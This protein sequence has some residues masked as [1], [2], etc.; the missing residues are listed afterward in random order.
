MAV[1]MEDANREALMVLL[2][3]WSSGSDEPL[4]AAAQI[5]FAAA[6][7]S[8]QAV[9]AIALE[10]LGEDPIEEEVRMHW[11]KRSVQRIGKS[12]AVQQAQA[13]LVRILEQANVPYMILKGAAAA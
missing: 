12:R 8:Q 11:I 9:E 2:R 3:R 10:G 1:Q 13:E 6:E 7:S 4:P 5:N